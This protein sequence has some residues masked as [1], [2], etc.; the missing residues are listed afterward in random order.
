MRRNHLFCL[1]IIFLVLLAYSNSFE[2]PFQ[3]DDTHVIERN[4]FIK[5][6]A[7]IPRF[8][9]N[10][11]LGSGLIKETSSYRPLLMASFVFNFLLGRLDVF[12]YHLYNSI[13]HLLCALLVYFVTLYCFRFTGEQ[14]EGNT[15]RYQLVALFA[16]LIFGLHPVQVESVT[17]ISGRSSSFST[18]FYLASFFTYL[19]YRLTRKMQYLFFSSL[20]YGCS[21]LIK[22]T[23]V[24]LLPILIIFL[25]MLPDERNFRK[26]YLSLLPHF[27]LSILYLGIREYFFGSFHYG[28]PV[29][30]SFYENVL[31]QP[32]AWVYYL[33]TLLLPLNLNVDYDFPVSHSVVESG[34]ILSFS[35]LLGVTLLIAHLS[36]FNRFVGFWALWFALN[37]APTNSLIVLEDLI[38]D[39]WLYL[40]SIGVAV[41]MG[42]GVS[43]VYQTWVEGGRRTAKLIFFFLCFLTIEMYGYSTLLRNFD[44]TSQRA[45]WEDA[46]FKSPNKARPYNGLAVAFIS[47]NRFKEAEQNLYRAIA[48]APRWGQPYL[49]LGYAYSLEGNW[50]KAIEFYEKAIPLNNIFLPEVYNNLGLV[51][52]QQGRMEEA[53]ESF[54]KAID[55]R[56]HDPFPY[57]NLGAY[58][59]K[60]GETDQ[61]IYY[62]EKSLKLAPENHIIY[63]ALSVLYERKGWKEKSKEAHYK[64]LKYAPR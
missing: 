1:I 33:G 13:V 14:K 46:V 25:S 64:F 6:P 11:Q 35:I 24:T 8:F 7:N 22:E 42:Y 52:L 16:A 44:W 43:W 58:Y 60:K 41:L 47:K 40:P 48:L 32:R 23:G 15:L 31:T 37:L 39:R 19:Q 50:D 17:Y 20:S 29:I 51:Y 59:E 45:L 5:D 21:L 4:A 3:Y 63:G 57:G 49:N 61:A 56:P 38:S 36:R 53:R 18:L 9:V 2:N 10:P 54:I 26:R 55:L 27:L 12:G 28:N 30:R 62:Y 34:V